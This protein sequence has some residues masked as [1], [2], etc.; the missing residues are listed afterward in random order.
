MKHWIMIMIAAITIELA[1]CQAPE[2]RR[3]RPR[4]FE[5]PRA[6]G[7]VAKILDVK[8]LPVGVQTEISDVI[9][10]PDVLVGECTWRILVGPNSSACPASVTYDNRAGGQDILIERGWVYVVVVRTPTGGTPS[11]S[12]WGRA[13]TRRVSGTA[14]GT[15]F[16]VQEKD[17][18]HRVIQLSG[19]M[20][21]QVTVTLDAPG[22]PP[23]DLN[24]GRTYF[25]VPGGAQRLPPPGTITDPNSEIGKFV[26]GVEDIARSAG[27]PW[28]G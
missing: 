12:S 15:R 3:D 1:S 19:G 6:P 22:V 14:P 27:L 8:P 23:Q 21:D 13:R 20:S 16:L 25:E 5:F 7:V 26:A 2:A 10:L 9:L 11:G 4:R 24:S 28:S 17:D 18:L